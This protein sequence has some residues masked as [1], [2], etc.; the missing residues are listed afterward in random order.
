MTFS[1]T[2]QIFGPKNKTDSVLHLTEFTLDLFRKSKGL[3]EIYV[4]VAKFL[5][6]IVTALSLSSKSRKMIACHY[7]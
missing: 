3:Q 7:I 1:K 2:S 5:W 4:S 6:C